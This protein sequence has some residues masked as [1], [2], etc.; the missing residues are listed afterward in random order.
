MNIVS[1]WAVKYRSRA[2]GQNMNIV[3]H[4]TAKYRSRASRHN[5]VNIVSLGREIYVN[6]IGTR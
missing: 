6:G 4:W 3:C 2:S 1:H 5:D